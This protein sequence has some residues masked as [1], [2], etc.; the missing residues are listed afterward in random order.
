MASDPQIAIRTWQVAMDDI[1]KTK[2][3]ETQARWRR[4]INHQAYDSIR[5]L[6]ILETRA[7]HF[8]KV[9]QAGTVSTN[10]YLR[11]LHNFAVEL[12]WLPWPVLLKK[13]WP[14]IR[15]KEKRAITSDEH[16]RIIGIEWDAERKAYYQ[17][18]WHLGGSQSDIASL[19]A[20]DIHWP[21]RVISY[22]RKKTNARAMIHFSTEVEQIL[23]SLPAS[24]P[25]FSR[26]AQMHEKHRA[27]E[28]KRRCRRL[29][30][31]G[32]TLHSYRYA[33]AERAQVCGYPERYA[34]LALGHNSAALHR[35]YAR[36]A[37]VQLPPLEDYERLHAQN[38]IIPVPVQMGTGS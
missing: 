7:E 13:Q 20:E 28:F 23:R 11:R 16:L 33:W 4:A 31:Q 10:V 1:L 8:L 15:F 25:L 21:T 27:A 12:N 35:A 17:L 34:Q 19:C 30:I 9:L 32:V 36:K 29:S 26:I 14:K 5:H 2:H 18:L 3:N 37:Q 24:G 38:K 22:R 6:P